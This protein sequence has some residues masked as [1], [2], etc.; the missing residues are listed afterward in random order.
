MKALKIIGIILLI[1]IVIVLV[2]G[3]FLPSEVVVEK[4]ILIN[5]PAKTV[6]KQVNTMENWEKWTPFTEDAPDMVCTYEGTGVGAIQTWSFQ[7][8]SGSLSIIESSPYMSLVTE[9]DL[10]QD[11]KVNG[12]WTFTE[13]E[14]GTQV[15]WSINFSDLSYPVGRYSGLFMKGG[16]G[17]YLENGLENIKILAESLPPYPDVEESYFDAIHALTITD[18]ILMTD[19]ETKMGMYFGEI[20]NYMQRKKIDIIAPPFSLYYSWWSEGTYVAVGLPTD[21]EK[22][23]W[24]NIQPLVIGPT[25]VIKAMHVGPYETLMLTYSALEEYAK[26]FNKTISGPP[27]EFYLTDPT[28]DPDPNNWKTEVYFPVE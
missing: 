9:V 7:G 4:Q 2:V 20:I 3:I 26:E 10:M 14:E 5:A 15:N 19:M 11:T 13:T 25:N 24:N 22:K 21:G 1:V 17:P 8:D 28:Q 6:F 12:I 16:M 18:T 27:W 23:G